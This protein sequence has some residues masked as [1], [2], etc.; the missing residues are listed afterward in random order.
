MMMIRARKAIQRALEN[1]LGDRM[2]R[3][4]KEIGKRRLDL[5]KKAEIDAGIMAAWRKPKSVR[6][7]AP[8]GVS[9]KMISIAY[10]DFSTTTTWYQT[11]IRFRSISSS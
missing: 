4:R 3:I 11:F 10:I 9:V 1:L 6:Y 8:K 7:I 5:E 2:E